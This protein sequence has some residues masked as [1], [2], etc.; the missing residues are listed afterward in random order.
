[1]IQWPKPLGTASN[2]IA[3]WLNWVLRCAKQCEPIDIEGYRIEP[4]ANGWKARKKF[5]TAGGTTAP[6]Q[7]STEKLMTITGLGSGL[8]PPNYDLLICQDSGG[9]TVYVAKSI[10]ARRDISQ[11]YFLDNG[12]NITQTYS[13]FTGTSSD[14]SYG[15]NFRMATDGTNTELQ[16]MEKRYYAQGMIP[17]TKGNPRQYQIYVRD[18]NAPTGVKD[19]KGNDVTRIEVKPFRAW[20]RYAT[21]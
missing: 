17:P 4:G 12:D 15:D 18:T 14:P 6:A 8:T 11:E 19:P 7:P 20:I 13:Y 2:A 21:Q 10:E 1:M 9:A 3:M 16:A 5:Q